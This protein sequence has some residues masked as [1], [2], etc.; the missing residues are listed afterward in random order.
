MA[1]DAAGVVEDLGS[2]RVLLARHVAGL[3]EQRQVDERRRVALRTGVAVPVPG[4]A[5]VAALLDDP[6]VVDADVAQLR[7]GH[8]PGEPAAD[9]RERHLVEQRLAFGR[10]DVGIL[11][12][13]LEDPR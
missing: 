4:A 13:V 9:E 10:L 3:L 11:D 1:A 12:V 6:D 2:V 8:Q 5:E 7:G